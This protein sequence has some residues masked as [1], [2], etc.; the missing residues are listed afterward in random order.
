MLRKLLLSALLL[1]SAPNA[2]AATVSLSASAGDRSAVLTWS[3]ANGSINAQEVY[4]DTD[5]NPTGRV[6]IATL[7]A[8]TRSYSATGLTNGTTYYFWIKARQSSNGV[9][10]NSNAASATPAG[11]TSTSSFWP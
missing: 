1:T 4:R 10:I 7:S 8:S 6:R 5:S 2:L 3:V 9:W 11:S